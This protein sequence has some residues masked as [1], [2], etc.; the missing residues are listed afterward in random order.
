[1]YRTYITVDTKEIAVQNIGIS[2]GGNDR[3]FGQDT[4]YPN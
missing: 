3:L 2:D 4:Y 1:M